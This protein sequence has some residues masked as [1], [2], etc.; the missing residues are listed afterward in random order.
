MFKLTSY[1]AYY[2]W[3]DGIEVV[4]SF[5]SLDEAKKCLPNVLKSRIIIFEN[6]EEY[7]ALKNKSGEYI[8]KIASSL[9]EINHNATLFIVKGFKDNSNILET[10]A[11]FTDNKEALKLANLNYGFIKEVKISEK[12]YKT[13]NDYRINE[14]DYNF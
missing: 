14:P 8:E 6:L 2:N 5:F 7:N 9:S 11:L 3:V 12:I 13:Y 1:K 4:A 10:K